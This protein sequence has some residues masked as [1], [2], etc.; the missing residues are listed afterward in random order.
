MSRASAQSTPVTTSSSAVLSK[1]GR[2]TPLFDLEQPL[3]P[4]DLK[5]YRAAL[6]DLQGNILK[7]HGRDA[8]VHVFLTFQAG[9]QVAA[10]RFLGTFAQR[11]TSAA[12]HQRQKRFKGTR[13]SKLFVGVALSAKGYEYLEYDKEYLKL[14]FSPEFLRGMGKAALDDPPP[15]RWEAKFQKPIHAMVI[16]AHDD[17]NILEAELGALQRQVRGFAEI[18]TEMGTAI[19]NGRHVLE[20]FGYRDGVSQPLFFQ[21]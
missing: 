13:K 2:R 20:H 16:L 10:R 18:S 15:E 8:A 12:S 17:P 21:T 1:Y 19:H 3:T 14:C 11:V 9:K 5:T 4:A 7:S 6:R